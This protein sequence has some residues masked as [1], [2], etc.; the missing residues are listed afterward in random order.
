MVETVKTAKVHKCIKYVVCC[1][2]CNYYNPDAEDYIPDDVV[3]C[4]LCDKKFGIKE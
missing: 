1:P 4:E 2:H 3:V